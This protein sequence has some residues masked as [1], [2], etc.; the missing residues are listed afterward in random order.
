M[1]KRATEGRGV[2]E[3][4]PVSLNA[5]AVSSE[6]SSA[7]DGVPIGGSITSTA[8]SVPPE[9]A[10]PR[11]PPGLPSSATH[12]GGRRRAAGS[13]GRSR[14]SAQRV[15]KVA[16]SGGRRRTSTEATTE[17]MGGTPEGHTHGLTSRTCKSTHMCY[18]LTLACTNQLRNARAPCC[19]AL[20][21]G[22]IMECGI[23][24]S[25]DIQHHE[26]CGR[27]ARG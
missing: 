4:H 5:D 1:G 24:M 8:P 22:G 16:A 2:Q 26:R 9:H 13:A 19:S 14:T 11:L 15:G 7:R 21:L 17:C 18:A 27:Q 10:Q 25:G 12:N 23:A 20:H 3:A 6:I